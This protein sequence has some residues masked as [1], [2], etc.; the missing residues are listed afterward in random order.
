[1]QYVNCYFSDATYYGCAEISKTPG[2][3]LYGT[4]GEICTQAILDER[5][6]KHY[7]AKMTR[8]QYDTYTKG[9]VQNKKRVFDCEGLL[10]YF[11]SKNV[12]ADYCYNNWCE[13]E[14]GE[15]TD[16]VIPFLSTPNALGCAVFEYNAEKKKMNHV[17]FIVGNINGDPVIVEARGIAY[18]VTMTRL[19]E[20]KFTYWGRPSKVIEYPESPIIP[21]RVTVNDT[22]TA[23]ANTD[24]I[25]S[26]QSMLTAWG[27]PVRIDGRIGAETRAAFS[28]FMNDNKTQT[29]IDLM[30]NG[31]TVF[32]NII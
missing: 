19:S 7:S 6:E 16:S 5:F 1:M 17:G 32:H 12:T 23:P 20:R 22:N 9:W 18:G 24:R 25:K 11:V 2:E 29:T 8:E 15:I 26:L 31:Q 3:Y 30:L 4:T 14:K 10:D 13:T 27:Y 28:T 21:P